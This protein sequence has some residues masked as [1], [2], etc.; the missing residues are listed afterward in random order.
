MIYY[1]GYLSYYGTIMIIINQI[2]REPETLGDKRDI[3]SVCTKVMNR[4]ASNRLISKQEAVVL[5]GGLA[6]VACSETIQSVS[7]SN[8]KRLF[9][10]KDISDSSFLQQYMKRPQ[11]HEDLCLNDYFHYVKNRSKKGTETVIPHFIG[12]N[13]SPVYPITESYAKQTLIVYRP[14]RTYPNSDDWKGEFTC[15]INQIGTP[16]SAK[17]TYHR[18]MQRWYSKMAGYEPV[19]KDVDTSTNPMPEGIAELMTLTGLPGKIAMTFD[20]AI[21]KK[22]DR[23]LDFEWDRDPVVRTIFSRFRVTQN[24]NNHTK[25]DANHKANPSIS[26]FF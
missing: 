1:T 2:N 15:F 20:E 16:I 5:L 6:L 10:N 19:S 4:A 14:W 22:L 23:G 8:S 25:N 24:K 9:L 11:V 26:F 3:K 7:I 12:I 17:L 18:I 21:L 13:G